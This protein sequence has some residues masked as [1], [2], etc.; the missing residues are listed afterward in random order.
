MYVYFFFWGGGGGGVA[1][2]QWQYMHKGN[3]CLQAFAL[4]SSGRYTLFFYWRP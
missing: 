3:T 2:A 1:Q 4:P